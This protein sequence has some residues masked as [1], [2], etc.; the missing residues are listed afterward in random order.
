MYGRLNDLWLIEELDH[1]GQIDIEPK[2]VIR[3]NLPACTEPGDASEDSDP[4][5]GMSILQ[6][7]EDLLH[8]GFSL[9]VIGFA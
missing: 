1:Q 3:A 5:N 9:S 8:Q 6:K 4:L 7:C 2:N